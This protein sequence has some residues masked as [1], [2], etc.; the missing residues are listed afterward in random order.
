MSSHDTFNRSINLL[1]VL[2][3]GGTV[4]SIDAIGTQ[5]AIAEQIIDKGGDYVLCVKAN[6][7]LSLQE[8]EAYFRPL[9]QKYILLDEQTELSHG[10]IE[11]RRYESILNPL[12]I[13]ANEVLTRWKGLRSIHKVVRK[14]RDKKSDKTSEEVAYYISSLTDL[15]L[16]KQAIRGHWAIENKLHHCLDVYFGDDASHKRTPAIVAM[17]LKSRSYWSV[18]VFANIFV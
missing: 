5:T 10:R 9:F 1:D 12:E 17:V 16:L 15:S 13:E 2:D 6:Q 8:I 18:F 7:S 11:T 4:V 14:R 3:L